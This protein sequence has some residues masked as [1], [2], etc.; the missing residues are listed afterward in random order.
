M[1]TNLVVFVIPHK[2]QVVGDFWAGLV[3]EVLD[4]VGVEESGDVVDEFVALHEGKQWVLGW[5]G[6]LTAVIGGSFRGVR[7][8]WGEGVKDRLVK[9]FRK[10]ILDVEMR[11]GVWSNRGIAKFVNCGGFKFSHDYSHMKDGGSEI[12]G[13]GIKEDK[14]QSNTI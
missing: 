11:I 6:E 14:S 13:T 7:F 2:A 12:I 8:T 1:W 10:D 4:D 5:V 3:F 9:R